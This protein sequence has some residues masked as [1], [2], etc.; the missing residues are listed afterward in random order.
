MSFKSQVQADIHAVFLNPRGFAELA[1]VAGHP[2]VPVVEE[3]LEL[4]LPQLS[5]DRPGMSYEGVTLYVAES[6]VPDDLRTGK[7]TTYRGEQWY[8]L[9][10]DCEAGL[11]TIRLYR[12]R[13]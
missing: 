4:E 7:A 6:D 2:S 13:V 5:D 11:K 1:E 8:V 9:S 10:T 12:E 3:N